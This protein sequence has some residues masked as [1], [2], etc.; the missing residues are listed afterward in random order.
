MKGAL[1]IL[2][3]EGAIYFMENLPGKPDN[4]EPI[5]NDIKLN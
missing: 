1:G 2:F 5:G 3:P 4:H